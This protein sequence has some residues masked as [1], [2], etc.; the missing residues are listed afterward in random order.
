MPPVLYLQ[1]D[2]CSRENKNWKMFGYI[3]WLVETRV[4]AKVE[5]RFLPV[6]YE[7]YPL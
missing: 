6:G 2:N 5:L 7:S 3:A 4:F 1:M